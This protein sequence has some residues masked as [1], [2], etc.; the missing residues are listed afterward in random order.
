[1]RQ[2]AREGS[3]CST[4]PDCEIRWGRR[5]RV[6]ADRTQ[7]HRASSLRDLSA[8]RV[9]TWRTA[10]LQPTSRGGGKHPTAPVLRFPVV[11]EV[12]RCVASPR[13]SASSPACFHPTCKGKR[14][15]QNRKGAPKPRKGVRLPFLVWGL[16]SI[17]SMELPW[18]CP[19]PSRAPESRKKATPKGTPTFFPGALDRLGFGGSPVV[20]LVEGDVAALV[21]S[22]CS[23]PRS[24][25]RA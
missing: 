5:R 6:V 14:L 9:G 20:G 3:S 2:L 18:P 25:A 15:R 7:P 13:A 16:P 1:M 24:S 8:P 4:T 23:R 11:V 12:L 22:G 17:T 10:S 21:A 19:R